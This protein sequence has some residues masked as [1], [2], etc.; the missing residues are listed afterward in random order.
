[1]FENKPLG[2]VWWWNVLR[3]HDRETACGC[4]S[5]KLW[6][7]MVLGSKLRLKMKVS[8]GKEGRKSLL[9]PA[10]DFKTKL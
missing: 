3:Q 10:P 4:A 9:L 6:S 7:Q 2:A 8:R 5:G 1:V